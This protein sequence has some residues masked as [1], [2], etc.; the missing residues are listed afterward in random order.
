VE[1]VGAL[2]HSLEGA[3][4]LRRRIA[5]ARGLAAWSEVVGSHLAER[6][7]ALRLAGGRL[8]VICHGSALRQELAFHKREILRRFR[9]VAGPC[10]VV[11]EVVLLESD[12]NLSSLVRE[13]EEGE[14]RARTPGRPGPGPAEAAGEPAAEDTEEPSVAARMAAAYPRF[15]AAAYREEMRRIADGT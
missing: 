2:L 3:E 14:R 11:R 4:V 5:E 9:D 7:R 13:A 6:T 1:R 12:E 8:F 15:D 10:A